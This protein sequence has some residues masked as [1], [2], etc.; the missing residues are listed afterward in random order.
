MKGP[1]YVNQSC[2]ASHASN[3]LDIIICEILLPQLS[4]YRDSQT[5]TNQRRLQARSLCPSPC[6]PSALLFVV[7]LPL[8]LWST[9]PFAP[10]FSRPRHLTLHFLLS[11]VNFFL[12]IGTGQSCGPYKPAQTWGCA[13][14]T[15][16]TGAP[17]RAQDLPSHSV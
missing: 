9:S 6:G 11:R 17:V 12:N 3:G 16:T 5:L 13:V 15:S 8:S 14:G 10:F 2:V 1:C 7:P 4:T